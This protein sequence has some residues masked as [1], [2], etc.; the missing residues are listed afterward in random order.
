MNS[1]IR[2]TLWLA[3]PVLGLALVLSGSCG[4]S[5]DQSTTSTEATGRSVIVIAI[6]GLRADYLG[7]LGA[8]GVKTPALDAL[9]GES[10][11][12]EQAWAQ[13]P[14][15]MPSLASLLTG[16]YPTT[17]GLVEPGD[18]LSDEALTLAEAAQAAGLMTAAFVQGA[19]GSDFGLAQGF[20]TYEVNPEPGAAALAHLEANADAEM[21]LLVAGW[22]AAGL[23][24]AENPPEGYHQRLTEV[25]ASRATDEPILL[26]EEDLSFASRAYVRHI[27]YLDGRVGEFVA[28][29]KA[30]GW[31][32]RA[33]LVI[34]GTSGL[35]LQEH[36]TL[37][38][39]GLYPEN[40]RIP[41]LIRAPGGA[42]PGVV[43]KVVEIVD[44]MPTLA[45]A[46]GAD[47]PTGLQGADLEPIIAGGG[48][49]PYVAFSETDQ[50][51]GIRS[52]VMDGMQLVTHADRMALFDLASDPHAE[53]DAA[54]QFPKRAEVLQS[55]LDAWSK[56]VAASSLDPER[57]T[58]DLDEETLEQ[59]RSLGYIQ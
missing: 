11:V 2:K 27:E 52:V 34:A 39:E 56:M 32:D 21:L 15:M 1:K 28:Q 25:I 55:H 8:E 19:G 37:F 14:S 45:A 9:A 17:H 51:G 57:R 33:T 6:D 10:T 46:T 58:E 47:L 12:F 7:F 43:K 29:I 42:R 53:T 20:D 48:T 44:L 16:L 22:S 59:L 13:S 23:E 35:A 54:E 18:S 49:P 40:I 41:L 36:G 30:S 31:L 26:G 38:G 4:G 5:G 50:D 24:R 3:A